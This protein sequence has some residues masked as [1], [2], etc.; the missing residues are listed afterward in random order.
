MNPIKASLWVLRTVPGIQEIE[1]KVGGL[2]ADAQRLRVGAGHQGLTWSG[3]V[4]TA[5]V[6]GSVSLSQGERLRVCAATAGPIGRGYGNK[7]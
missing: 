6:S 3:E 2:L 4:R 1:I 7:A 5:V